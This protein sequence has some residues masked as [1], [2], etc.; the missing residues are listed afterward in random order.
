[1]LPYLEIFGSSIP[2]FGLCATIGAAAGILLYIFLLK[3]YKIPTIQQNKLFILLPFVIIGGVFFAIVAD[4]IAHWGESPWYMPEGITFAGGLLGGFFIYT[5]LYGIVVDKKYKNF[6]FNT[7]PLVAPFLVVHSIGRIGCFCAGC[8]YGCP[9]NFLGVYFPEGS[10]AYLQYGN[11]AVLP[12]Q[13][14]ESAFLM[15]M[16]IV[17]LFVIKKYIIPTYFL[18]YGIFRFFLEFF[19]GDNR[20]SFLGVFSPSQIYSII[21]L[22]IG[23]VF[24]IYEIKQRKKTNLKS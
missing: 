15:L 20:G 2:M 13:L 7:Q 1:M 4:K 23:I 21:F 12:T 19:R 24:L 18:S 17:V 9:T 3:K 22:T 5:L 6:I 10:L 16:A 14:I 11:V 8:C